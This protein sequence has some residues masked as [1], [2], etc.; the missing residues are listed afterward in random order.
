M[1]AAVAFPCC[2]ITSCLLT[3]CP[4]P[5]DPLARPVFPVS[6]RIVYRGQPIPDAT[7]CLQPVKSFEDNKPTVLPR[8]TVNRAGD[9]TVSTYNTNDGAPVGQYYVK[10][11]W[12]GP[13]DGVDE[14]AQ[15][16]LCQFGDAGRWR[17]QGFRT[18]KFDGPHTVDRVIPLS[19]GFFDV[20][21]NVRSARIALLAHC[22][23]FHIDSFLPESNHAKS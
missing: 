1:F 16:G 15:D 6:G 4:E 3:G 5:D 22:P 10:V 20:E 7:V 8:A 13:L 23:L 2:L 11:S 21:V 19:R 9:F 14:D 18:V 17:I 12:L